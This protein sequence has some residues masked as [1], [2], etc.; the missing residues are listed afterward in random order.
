MTLQRLVASYFTYRLMRDCLNSSFPVSLAAGFVYSLLNTDLGE[1]CFMHGLNEPGVP[2]LLWFF[3][4]LPFDRPWA[5]S[6]WSALLGILV[7]LAM[8]FIIGTLFIMPV[9]WLALQLGREDLKGLRPRIVLTW[10]IV[11]FTAV[12]LVRQVP[13]LWALALAAPE[14]HRGV[15]FATEAINWSALF[16]IRVHHLLAWWPFYLGTFWWMGKSN[17]R[18]GSDRVIGVFLLMGLVV[19][20]IMGPVRHWL[21]PW[22]GFLRGVDFQRFWIVAP[23]AFTMATFCALDRCPRWIGRL[24]DTQSRVRLQLPLSGILAALILGLA[25]W[26]SS[27]TKYAHWRLQRYEGYNWRALFGNDDIAEYVRKSHEEG[28]RMATAGAHATLHPGYL[29]AYGA[30]T[31]DGHSPLYGIRYHRFWSQVIGPLMN[32]DPDVRGFHNWGAHVYLHHA[33]SGEDYFVREIPFRDWYNLDLLSFAGVR[34]FVSDKRIADSRLE[35]MPMPHYEERMAT[36]DALSST[37]KIRRYATGQNPGRRLFIY[38]NPDALPR[39][40]LVPSLRLF[41]DQESLWNAMGKSSLQ[42][43][44]ES[45]FL[46]SDEAPTTSRME[47]PFEG[48]HSITVLEQRP[49]FRRLRVRLSQPGFLVVTDQYYPWW[50]W[51]INGQ[52]ET[53]YPAYGVF[54][55]LLLPAGE[56]IVE[57]QYRPPYQPLLDAASP[58]KKYQ[59]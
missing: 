27:E 34:Y 35:L 39:H 46:I 54:L 37:E 40:F 49:D 2:L 32:R 58:D 48:E 15:N 14:S 23:A 38:R 41:P 56:C 42:D 25:V 20:P 22:I 4:R 52:E 44:R 7:G 45:V 3:W 29:L 26:H 51:N 31:A 53:V 16:Q 19:S 10:T 21:S 55:A 6:G 9:L 18:R 50:Y 36:W 11:L 28:L 43:L 24:T 30:E 59:P 17:L 13:T 5:A 1:T 12:S 47:G 8:S 57:G 33:R